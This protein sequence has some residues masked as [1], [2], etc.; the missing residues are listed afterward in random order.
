MFTVF[1]ILVL[2]ILIMLII[3]HTYHPFNH[4]DEVEE[5]VVTTTTVTTTHQDVPVQQTY[6]IAGTIMRGWENNQPFV[7]DPADQSK[8][9]V[10]PND[11]MYEDAEGKI[12]H[13]E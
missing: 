2:L 13:L 8:T 1:L 7:F 9:Y 11:D 6:V 5:E 4:F 10:N 12:W 3:Q